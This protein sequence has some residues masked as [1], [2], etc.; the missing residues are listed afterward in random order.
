MSGVGDLFGRHWNWKVFVF[1]VSYKHTLKLLF[2]EVVYLSSGL[3]E[4]SKR[5]GKANK[6]YIDKQIPAVDIGVQ[7]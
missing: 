1:C 4:H 3:R 7:S 5:V 6:G 2:R